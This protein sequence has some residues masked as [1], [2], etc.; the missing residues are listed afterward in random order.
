MD[1]PHLRRG[2]LDEKASFEKPSYALDRDE[3]PSQKDLVRC[4]A[5]SLSVC[6]NAVTQCLQNRSFR[7][8]LQAPEQGRQ[9]GD[10]IEMLEPCVRHL[11]S[12]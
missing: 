7:E 6:P 1:E 10:D 3:K 12:V 5:L 4:H 2:W 11:D 9:H 8:N